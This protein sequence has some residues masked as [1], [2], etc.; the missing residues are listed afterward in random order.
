MT[1]ARTMNLQLYQKFGPYPKKQA[2]PKDREIAEEVYRLS[3]DATREIVKF[4]ESDQPAI[5]ASYYLSKISVSLLKII[6]LIYDLSIQADKKTED[7]P[8][9]DHPTDDCWLLIKKEANDQDSK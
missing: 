8:G 9:I 3:Q 4:W 2:P 6:T 7:I 5:V 1:K